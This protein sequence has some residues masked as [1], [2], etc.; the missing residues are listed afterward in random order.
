MPLITRYAA[1]EALV[2]PIQP[3]AQIWRLVLAIVV[4][5]LVWFA[6]SLLI[7]PLFARLMPPED[8]VRLGHGETPFAMVI[9][10]GSF[11]FF[12]AGVALAVRLLQG[13]V[14][15]SVLGRWALFWRQFRQVSLALLILVAGIAL[16]PPYELDAPLGAGLP[17]AQWLTLLPLS[18]LAVLVQTSSEEIVFRGFLQQTLAAR[19]SAPLIWIGLPSVLFGLAHY[20]P[21]DAGDNACLIVVWAGVFGLCAAD[22]TARAGTL[23]PAIALH[24]FNNVVALVVFASP[25]TMNGLALYILPY[26]MSDTEALRPWLVVEFA[27]MLVGW[28]AARL[29]IRR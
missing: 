12:V 17:F 4:I 6:L 20:M 10:L 19:F 3:R 9:L 15:G 28:L 1:H 24:F 21:E 23:A 14:L 8:L 5:A 13:R 2:R 16:L 7:V 18:L 27:S 11:G 26:G 22:L 25:T 29:A